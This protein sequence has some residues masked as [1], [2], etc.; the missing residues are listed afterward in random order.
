MVPWWVRALGARSEMHAVTE[1]PFG[2]VELRSPCGASPVEFPAR[3]T[4]Q[5][6]L[7]SFH[8]KPKEADA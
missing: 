6:P 2:A 8:V 4:A 5:E 1:G 7:R 3:A